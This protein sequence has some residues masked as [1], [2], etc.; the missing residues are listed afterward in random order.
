MTFLHDSILKLT[1]DYLAASERWPPFLP[2]QPLLAAPAFWS[3][4]DTLEH[5]SRTAPILHSQSPTNFTFFLAV[6]AA[7]SGVGGPRDSK[8][9]GG[10][11]SFTTIAS[12]PG[13]WEFLKISTGWTDY[14][15]RNCVK[16]DHVLLER[17]NQLWVCEPLGVHSQQRSKL[18]PS[19]SQFQQLLSQGG[20]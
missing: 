4:C 1:L 15:S 16:K 17:E 3:L 6:T 11:L 2:A 12:K 5:S 20:D 14:P 18:L 13:I 10:S 7:A 9:L 19:T 8:F